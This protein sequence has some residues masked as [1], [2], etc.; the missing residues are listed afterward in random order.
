MSFVRSL[1]LQFQQ[2]FQQIYSVHLLAL[3][4]LLG[5]GV[6]YLVRNANKLSPRR[7]VALSIACGIVAMLAIG[8]AYRVPPVADL[9]TFLARPFT[10]LVHLPWIGRKI[11][12]QM[13]TLPH[14]G[15][16]EVSL[17]WVKAFLAFGA[18]ALSVY[19][20]S[21]ILLKNAPP[22][23]WV[24]G[25]A[26]AL[27]VL[28]I[29]AYFRF[30]DPGYS[31]FYH[32]WEF[33]HYYLGSKYDR[34]LGYER[35]YKC[36]AVA[37]ADSGQTNE[38]R[39]RKLRDLAEDQLVP[40]QTVLDHSG[41]CRDRF[42]A[43]RWDAFKADVRWFRNSSNLQ[44]WND[45]Q[46]DHGYNPPPV[47]TVMGHFWS[48]LRPA[49][50]GY[51][52]FLSTFDPLFFVGIFGAIYWAFGWRVFAVAAIFW[53]CQQPAEYSWTGGAFMRQDWL[54]YLVLSGCLIRKR[55]YAL[56]GAA[57]AYSTLLRVF[58]GLL[59]AGWVVVA[60]VHYWKHRVMA[61]HHKRVMLGGV[62][63][64]VLL[65]GISLAVAGGRAYPEFYRHIQVH[66]HTPLTNNMGLAT[67]LAQGGYMPWEWSPESSG[68]M[69]FKRDEKLL[70]PF[71]DWKQMRRDRLTAFRPL[72]LV[73]LVAI[74][75]AF[76]L[77]VRRVK[78][79][80]IAQALSL[81]VFVS[82]VEVTCYYYS[83]FILAAYLS[84]LRRGLE[85]WVLCVAGISQLLVVNRI[86]SYYYDDRYTAQAALF[87]GFAFS[88][89][90]AYWPAMGK[91]PK[92]VTK[93]SEPSPDPEKGAETSREA[94]EST[95][96]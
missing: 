44:Y 73:L 59:L 42:T 51:I 52:L 8:A 53:G 55:Y 38:V 45:M 49:T 57:F 9:L 18:A 90:A 16:N 87:C 29:G 27:A 61:P 50:N 77:V 84:R 39:A 3:V 85:Q 91:K 12:E 70:D 20:G 26:L 15:V 60:G 5:V 6:G 75:I 63:A 36:V 2:Q 69:E 21:R 89:L 10:T 7:F 81:A 67:L 94:A 14:G 35:L 72:H 24:K 95:A 32:R 71:R 79:L 31:N 47:W 82:L 58:P 92:D 22:K 41:E 88:L 34:E 86:V 80:W 74:G 64:T 19:E 30:G 17:S 13:F 40:A 43:E 23:Q 11:P 83:I 78:S 28:G 62:A 33:F 54:F 46:K 4:L 25:I 66:N 37:Q 68:R 93:K 48:S 65:V 1:F 76:F 96:A 56:G